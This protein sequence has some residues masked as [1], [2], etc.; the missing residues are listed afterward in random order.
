MSWRKKLDITLFIEVKP[1]Q[2]PRVYGKHTVQPKQ[3]ELIG[4][5]FLYK[6]AKPIDE[7]MYVDIKFYYKHKRRMDI[8]NLCKAVLDGMQDANIISD[9]FLVSKLCAERINEHDEN[10]CIITIFTVKK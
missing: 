9:D 6:R 1:H 10:L 8:D 5:L 2:R 3:N 4:G 7:Q